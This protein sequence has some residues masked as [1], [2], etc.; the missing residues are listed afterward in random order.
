MTL[1]Y[2]DFLLKQELEKNGAENDAITQL[3]VM[4]LRPI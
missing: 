3:K 1:E 2:R 4:M